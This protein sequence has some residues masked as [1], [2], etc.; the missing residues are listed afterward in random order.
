MHLTK[1]GTAAW[2]SGVDT[3]RLSAAAGR[4]LGR[5]MGGGRIGA[6]SVER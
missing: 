2:G 5:G 6:S 3:P 4:P 1:G